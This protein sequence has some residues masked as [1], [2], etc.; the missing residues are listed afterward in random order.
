[1][2]DA[3][4]SRLGRDDEDYCYESCSYVQ[5]KLNNLPQ[6][7]TVRIGPFK[8]RQHVATIHCAVNT[9]LSEFVVLGTLDLDIVS[10]TNVGRWA[11]A[12]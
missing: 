7:R 3:R 1:M 9:T 5:K 6:S 4:P 10:L 8:L 2:F 11:H 12:R